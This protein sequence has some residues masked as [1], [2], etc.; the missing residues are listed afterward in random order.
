MNRLHLIPGCLIILCLCCLPIFGDIIFPEDIKSP[1]SLELWLKYTIKYVADEEEYW[2]TPEETVK[3]K[4][5]DC[6]DFAILAMHVLRSLGYRDVH[7]VVIAYKN[8]DV[9]HAVCVFKEH[10]GRYSVFSNDFYI[11]TRKY[12]SEA[13][14]IYSDGYDNWEY[15]KYYT[16]DGKVYKMILRTNYEN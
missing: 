3:L 14:V 15:L 1:D 9:A 2:Q 4:T 10:N 8:E 12:T 7:L 11:K 13:A 6:E 5:G 16:I